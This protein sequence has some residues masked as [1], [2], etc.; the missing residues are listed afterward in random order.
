MAI[1]IL[2][3]GNSAGARQA[4]PLGGTLKIN[5]MNT[6]VVLG[7]H[8]YL[9]YGSI[10]T[11]LTGIDA[12]LVRKGVLYEEVGF[13][14]HHVEDW[15]IGDNGV[16]MLSCGTHIMK[17]I[18]AGQSWVLNTDPSGSARIITNS[19]GSWMTLTDTGEL[20]ISNDDGDLWTMFDN[21][22]WPGT[23]IDIG[24][25]RQT[26]TIIVIT[27]DPADTAYGGAAYRTVDFGTNWTVTATNE[28]SGDGS[29]VGISSMTLR[30]NDGQWVRQVSYGDYDTKIIRSAD[31]GLTWEEVTLPVTISN[32]E[33]AY[34][35]SYAIGGE[36][37]IVLEGP[38]ADRSYTK[39]IVFS[40][41]K[42]S[43]R[44]TGLFDIPREVTDRFSLFSVKVD[45]TGELLDNVLYFPFGLTTV[46]GRD[47]SWSSNMITCT[48]ISSDGNDLFI[49]F[50][51]AKEGNSFLFKSIDCVGTLIKSSS[52]ADNLYM[53]II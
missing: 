26:G 36:N 50:I 53:R 6:E 22:L 47:F 49:G 31:D 38:S 34:A 41:N 14:P 43:N 18:D 2:I 5:S 27:N 37:F 51:S 11:D 30:G 28:Y 42:I 29:S 13:V 39:F 1:E 17:T 7:D 44:W 8:T 46:N 52:E 35:G 10:R 23:C 9:R 15:E 20:W 4:D 21:S 24:I 12:S 33:F 3:G 48:K 16:F 19:S 45:F 40:F 32:S 25:D